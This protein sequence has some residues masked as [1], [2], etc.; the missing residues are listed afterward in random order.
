MFGGSFRRKEAIHTWI[1]K[2]DV[3]FTQVLKVQ[4]GGVIVNS[5]ALITRVMETSNTAER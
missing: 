4:A 2:G 3:H 5:I 1:L